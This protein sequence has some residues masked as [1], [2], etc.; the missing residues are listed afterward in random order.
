MKKIEFVKE[1]SEYCE[2]DD[3]N[4]TL[5]TPFKSIEGY[6]SLAIMSIIAYVDEKFNMKLAALQLQNLVD[7]NSLIMLIGENN[8]EDD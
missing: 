4:Y 2:F 8:F 1:L 5:D 7:F 3:V 6:D